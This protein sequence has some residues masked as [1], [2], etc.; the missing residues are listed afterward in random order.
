VVVLYFLHY[1]PLLL[2]FPDR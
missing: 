1:I 2:A